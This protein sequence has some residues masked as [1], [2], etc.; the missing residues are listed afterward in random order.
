MRKVY[1]VRRYASSTPI[2]STY[3]SSDEEEDT[4]IE[5]PLVHDMTLYPEDWSEPKVYDTGLL[6]AD[7][8]PI[9]AETKPPPIGFLYEHFHEPS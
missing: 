1:H 4:E 6:D 5:Q 8:E 2:P 7:G 3:I 9:F